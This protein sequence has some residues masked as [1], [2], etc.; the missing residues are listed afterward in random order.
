M[1]E[2]S[3]SEWE[4]AAALGHRSLQYVGR[5]TRLTDDERDA[6]AERAAAL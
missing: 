6:L 3:R 5:Y 2:V 1:W 4:T